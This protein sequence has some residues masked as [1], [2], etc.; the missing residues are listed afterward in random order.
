MVKSDHIEFTKSLKLLNTT[1]TFD[2][3]VVGSNPTE[4]TMRLPHRPSLPAQDANRA[5]QGTASPWPLV[6]RRC[7]SAFA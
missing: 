5:A 1:V 7:W 2:H 6:S 4:L 3:G